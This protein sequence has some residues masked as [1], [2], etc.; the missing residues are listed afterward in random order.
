[1]TAGHPTGSAIPEH[2]TAQGLRLTLADG[3][4]ATLRL[5]GPPDAEAVERLLHELPRHDRYLRFFDHSRGIAQVVAGGIVGPNSVAVGFFRSG[6]LE[7]VANYEGANGHGTN[8]P[9]FAVTVTHSAQRQGIGTLLVNALIQAAREH[10]IR[11][12]AAD[13]L[14]VNTTMLRVLARTHLPMTQQSQ[15]DAI[16]LIIDVP[17]GDDVRQEIGTPR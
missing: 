16:H 5:L 1:M 6:S 12:L 3:S 4:A 11:R 10:G 8:P 7:G 9:E 13:V 2:I 14:A 15:C 17:E